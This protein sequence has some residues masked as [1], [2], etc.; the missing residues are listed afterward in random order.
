[1]Q[2]YRIAVIG[3]G[4]SGLAC[5]ARL[6]QLGKAHGA[7]IIEKAE[8]LGKKLSATGNGQGNVTNTDMSSS[9]YFGGGKKLAEKISCGDCSSALSLF[10]M[11]F[12]TDDCGRVYPAGR[13]ASSLTDALA[14]SL[15]NTAVVCGDGAVT[16]ERGFTVTLASGKKISSEYLVL[17]AGGKAQKQFGTDGSA[18]SLGLGF[19]HR[20][21]PIYPSLVQL[22]TDTAHIKTLKGIRADCRV[23]VVDDG[24]ETRTVRGDVIFTEYGVSGNAVFAVSPYVTDRRDVQLK[25][26]FL[27]GFSRDE[28]LSVLSARSKAGYDEAELLGGTLHNQLGRAIIRRSGGGA[29]DIARTVKNFRLNVSGTLGFDYA[30]VTRGGIDVSD[31]TDGLE[32]RLVKNLFF[33][34]E[35]LDVDGDC[36]GYNLHWAFTSGMAV[37]EEIAKRL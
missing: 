15:K 35:M 7:V 31:I 4:A 22:K 19:G 34:G 25:L 9:H 37:A 3:G 6:E 23:T 30:Q 16:A 20:L 26:E 2:H 24:R 33:T 12:S 32:S 5:A 21:T 18:Y 36:G 11:L 29:S 10:P 28:I 17:S 8:R 14:H 13:Q 27:P 1:M